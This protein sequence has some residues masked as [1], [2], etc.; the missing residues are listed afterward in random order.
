ML[1]R[2][3]LFLL[4]AVVLA[5][6]VFVPWVTTGHSV[7]SLGDVRVDMAFILAMPWFLEQKLHFGR[8]LVFTYGPLGVLS[9]NVVPLA[10]LAPILI[11]R[12]L[13]AALFV[14][15]WW[16]LT[17]GAARPVRILGFL[18]CL[19]LSFLG[20]EQ[21]Y[22]VAF[23][24]L[25]ALL[26]LRGG[27][28]VVVLVALAI[29]SAA[30]GYVKFNFFLVAGVC[31]LAIAWKRAWLTGV[32]LAS[33]LAIWSALGQRPVALLEWVWAS[34]DLSAGYAEA[35][36]KGFFAPYAILD[37]ALFTIGSVLTLVALGVALRAS[38]LGRKEAVLAFGVVAALVFVCQRHAWGGNQ[39]EQAASV[40]VFATFAG[41]ALPRAPFALP[42]CAKVIGLVAVTLLWTASAR[43]CLFLVVPP[44][45]IA[46]RALHTASAIGETLAGKV[47]EA[48]QARDRAFDAVAAMFPE[49]EAM[50]GTA[51]A[52][53]DNG[54]VL[55]AFPE[56]VYTPRPAYLSLNAHTERLV[57]LNSEFFTGE[58][59]PHNVLYEIVPLQEC[60]HHRLPASLDGLALRT[61]LSRYRV[62]STFATFAWFELD[63]GRPLWAEP[64]VTTREVGFG[65]RVPLPAG[66]V[67]WAELA[68]RKSLAGAVVDQL[69]KLPQIEI[70]YH[71][72]ARDEVYQIL[73]RIAAKGFFV[74]PVLRKTKD[75]VEL[76]QLLDR[77]ARGSATEI[78][79][80]S[81]RQ[82]DGPRG[83][84][85]P[86][87][88]ITS[89]TW[90]GRP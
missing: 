45:R 12:G 28:P 52:L 49:L 8:E 5:G 62:R 71:G 69:Y 60:V 47:T 76:Q 22:W 41:A 57:A 21:Y 25:A 24:V 32:F 86:R 81:I 42:A 53:P 78:S 6:F 64:G 15:G 23:P 19:V 43:N 37:V 11:A 44:D 31:F 14:A 87:V 75:V 17:A 89:R 35:M 39:L 48:A 26:T 13:L 55:L 79:S 3:L 50:R 54:A 7:N 18:C 1:V 90:N 9:G 66:A 68:I 27:T 72:G 46:E 67:V 73:P 70:C 63:P 38:E 74:A 10:W 34:L 58:R 30:V 83:L 84:W 65:E 82:Q 59:A 4:L 77:G 40:L 2:N 33:A 16:S 20:W 36:A 80:Y 56:I 51:D 88:V 85:E 61:I 29:A